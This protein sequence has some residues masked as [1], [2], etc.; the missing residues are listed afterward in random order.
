MKDFKDPNS[1]LSNIQNIQNHI[2]Q[3]NFDLEAREDIK[4]NIRVDENVSPSMFK[5]D[6]LIPGGF[7]ANSLTIRAMRADIFVLGDSLDDF[8]TNIECPCGKILDAQFWK[9]C[10]H[11]AREIK[12]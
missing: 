11:C 2:E 1:L 3:P 7:V 5:P 6:P 4:V 12:L 10:P 9:L 8:E